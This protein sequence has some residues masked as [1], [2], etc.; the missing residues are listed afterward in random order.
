MPIPVGVT[1]T[2]LSSNVILYI[3]VTWLAPVYCLF[4]GG[5]S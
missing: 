1:L 2:P 4:L 3:V 5:V